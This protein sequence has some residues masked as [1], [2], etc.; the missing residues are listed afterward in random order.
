MAIYKTQTIINIK[1]HITISR[2][3]LLHPALNHPNYRHHHR[4]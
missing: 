2:I 4:L 3:G 1:N